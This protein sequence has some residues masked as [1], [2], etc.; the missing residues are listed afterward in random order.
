MKTLMDSSGLSIVTTSMCY[1]FYIELL[2][3]EEKTHQFC[4]RE[5]IYT[6]PLLIYYFFFDLEYIKVF[7]DTQIYYFLTLLC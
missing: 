7:S 5:E 6:I 3:Q 1:M 2:I 4:Y